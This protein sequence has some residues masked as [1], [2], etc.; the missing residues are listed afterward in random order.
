VMY[1]VVLGLPLLA[2]LLWLASWIGTGTSYAR[3]FSTWE[4]LLTEARVLF[5]YMQW[6]LLPLPRSLSLYHDDFALSHGL[7]SPVSTLFAAL[8]IAALLACAVWQRRTRPL[9]SLGILWFF[10]GHALTATVIP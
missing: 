6:A 2:G 5:A 10:A 9:L 8:G 3:D 1:V 7:L 4:R